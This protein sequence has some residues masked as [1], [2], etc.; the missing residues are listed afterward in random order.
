MPPEHDPAEQEKARSAIA[1]AVR[2]LNSV[3]ARQSEVDQAA[4]TQRRISSENH[5]APNIASALGANRD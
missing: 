5:L 1:A 4:K 2:R 3:I